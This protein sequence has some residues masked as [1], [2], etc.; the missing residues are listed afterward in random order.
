MKV[1]LTAFAVILA[2]IV[3]VW[4]ET[5]R[6]VSTT[7]GYLLGSRADGGTRCP[8]LAYDPV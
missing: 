1:K 7:S 2:G 3:Q 8:F 4:C 5:I 6:G